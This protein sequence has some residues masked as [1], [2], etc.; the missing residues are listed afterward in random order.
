[1][2]LQQQML[3]TMQ[4]EILQGDI[5]V[6]VRVYRNKRKTREV[7]PR[8]V[9]RNTQINI[10]QLEQDVARSII[11]PASPEEKRHAKFGRFAQIDG[12]NEEVDA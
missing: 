5:V 11:K 1:M 8:S 3:R 4:D 10:A 2:S 12:W 7:L 9:A 6:L